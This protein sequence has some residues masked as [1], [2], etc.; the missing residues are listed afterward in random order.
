MQR[1]VHASFPRRQLDDK[2]PDIGGNRNPFPLQQIRFPRD[3]YGGIRQGTFLFVPCMLS[4][5]WPVSCLVLLYFPVWKPCGETAGMAGE[6]ERRATCVLAG[7]KRV[8]AGMHQQQYTPP[9]ATATCC[10]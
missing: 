2:A 1:P 8:L 6:K 5:H 7:R 3:I 10:S 9:T 4:P